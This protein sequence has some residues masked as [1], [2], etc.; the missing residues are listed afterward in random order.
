MSTTLQL[1]RGVSV[2]GT[3]IAA[4]HLFL[5]TLVPTPLQP[6]I[7][8]PVVFDRRL[9]WMS[10]AWEGRHCYT[11][12]SLTLVLFILVRMMTQIVSTIKQLHQSIFRP[13]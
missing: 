3:D 13:V 12:I 1:N 6:T 11:G 10:A 9:V 7:R 2:A 4:L 5:L 8:E